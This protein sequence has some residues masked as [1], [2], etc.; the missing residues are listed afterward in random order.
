MVV[1]PRIRSI[2]N[3]G[4]WRWNHALS[5][6]SMWPSML[7]WSFAETRC[8]IR[9]VSTVWAKA[10]TARTA[11]TPAMASPTSG[12]ASARPAEKISSN[13]GWISQLSAPSI[14]PSSIMNSS[15][16]TSVPPCART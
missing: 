8:P 3:P 6:R 14:A 2:S 5:N 4:G 11:K 16:S 1:S 15:A 7:V 9:A 10:D 12:I 13:I